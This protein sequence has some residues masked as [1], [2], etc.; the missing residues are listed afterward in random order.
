MTSLQKYERLDEK[1]KTVKISGVLKGIALTVNEMQ[2]WIMDA[3]YYNSFT[4]MDMPAMDID[5]FRT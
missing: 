5:K 3:E 2:K 1:Y 4:L